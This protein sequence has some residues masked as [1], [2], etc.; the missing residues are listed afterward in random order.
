MAFMK[1]FLASLNSSQK[2]KKAQKNK[3]KRSDNVTI[4][5]EQKYSTSF[6]L[7]ALKPKHTKIVIPTTEVIGETTVSGSKKPLRILIYTG[8]SSSIIL[9][10]FINKSL[11]VKNSR[12][13]TEWTTLGGKFHTKKQ[14]TV[15]FKLPEFFL[16]KTI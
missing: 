12:T 14:C 8:S 10:K 1:S 7:V 13:T 11:L 15:K 16:N 4:D 3:H 9:K 5:S 6:K 2:V